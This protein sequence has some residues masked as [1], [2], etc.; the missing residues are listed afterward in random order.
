MKPRTRG[1]VGARERRR[2][3]ETLSHGVVSQV[4]EEATLP[5]TPEIQH[6]TNLNGVGGAELEATPAES[7]S[8]DPSA[9]DIIVTAVRW[10]NLAL[11]TILFLG[12][13]VVALVVDYLLQGKHGLPLL[14]G[15]P[16]TQCN[17]SSASQ[18]HFHGVP[19]CGGCPR[20]I[21]PC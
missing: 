21:W 7:S 4:H 11:S 9:G 1:D 12:G 6:K 13:V 8:A 15:K 14:S 16:Q 2:Y 3:A 17:S 20:A 5:I 19:G 18:A 10:D